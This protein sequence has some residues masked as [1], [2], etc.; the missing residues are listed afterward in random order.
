MSF[1]CACC[2]PTCGIVLR[3]DETILYSK[4]YLFL[5]LTSIYPSAY[6]PFQ[7]FGSHCRS[8]FYMLHSISCC[9]CLLSVLVCSF[10][11]TSKAFS[12]VTEHARVYAANRARLQIIAALGSGFGNVTTYVCAICMSY[13][14]VVA[15]ILPLIVW[16]TLICMQVCCTSIEVDIFVRTHHCINSVSVLCYAGAAI[17]FGT[18][19]MVILLFFFLSLFCRYLE[20]AIDEFPTHHTLT[21]C[22]HNCI[23][24]KNPFIDVAVIFVNRSIQSCCFCFAWYEQPMC[25]RAT[26]F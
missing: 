18:L 22:T 24:W 20:W 16:C 17:K 7:L 15:D 23:T 1:S 3:P 8:P 10:G 25:A 19:A 26:Y 2:V 21:L 6:I 5:E 9:L 12:P 14:S 13:F 11:S 4:I